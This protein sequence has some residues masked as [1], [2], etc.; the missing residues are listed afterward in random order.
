VSSALPRALLASLLLVPFGLYFGAGDKH[1]PQAATAT[2]HATTRLLRVLGGCAIAF[3]LLYSFL[4]HKELRFLVPALPLF[5]IT[6]GVGLWQLFVRRR[7]SRCALFVFVAAAAG[8]AASAVLSAGFLYVSSFNYPGGRALQA[9]HASLLPEEAARVHID[10]S[11]A[12]SG[13]SRFGQEQEREGGWTV[14]YDKTEHLTPAL[15]QT[16]THTH[17][18]TPLPEL[19]GF[20]TVAQVE[21]LQRVKL[22]PPGPVLT[23][24][25]YVLRRNHYPPK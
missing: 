8:V 19:A 9:F 6:A 20:T 21:G 14:E 2:I 5:N 3:V 22:L 11:A 7:N 10:N 15:L 13:V 18:I 17:L 4:P 23:P 12:I 1:R 16:S 24:Q 25:L